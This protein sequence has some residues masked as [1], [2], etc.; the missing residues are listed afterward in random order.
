MNPLDQRY[1]IKGDTLDMKTFKGHFIDRTKRT[2]GQGMVEFA[3]SLP[4]FL[5]VA[6]G[7]ITFGHLLL[8]YVLTDTGSREG[9]R[10][11]AASGISATGV[12]YYRD[13][14]GIINTVLSS[15]AAAGVSQ[16]NVSV[17]YDGGPGKPVIGQC[18]PGTLGP[19]L[20]LG[21]RVVVSISIQYQPLV[22]LLN[23]NN[24]P[25]SVT[26][27]RTIIKNVVFGTPVKSA[28]PY[29][30]P[31]N[32]NTPTPTVP[33]NTPTS[34]HGPK[35]KGT[36]TPTEVPPT[37][38]PTRT[39]TATSTPVDAVC[40]GFQYRLLKD[41]KN[42]AIGVEID[43]QNVD[44]KQTIQLL[45][46]YLLWSGN[47]KLTQIQMVPPEIPIWTNP[48]GVSSP[49]SVCDYGCSATWQNTTTNRRQ[50]PAGGSNTIVY[51]FNNSIPNG[52][53]VVNLSFNNS[54]VISIQ[55]IP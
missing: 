2:A 34:T 35:P 50:I 25:I 22:P 5:F 13:C 15:A 45:R 4:V 44:K 31:T 55:D 43:V 42:K 7:I 47:T 10:Y 16:A 32:T 40:P 11:G 27:A 49:F 53:I 39:P 9:A 36:S 28:T 41:D 48:V 3:L 38:T 24:I 17:Y 19:D 52:N 30:P 23:L 1:L 21:N 29:V 14:D 6:L 54:C 12:Q 51:K 8:V 18:L 46:T 37:A 26:S 33:T 20:D